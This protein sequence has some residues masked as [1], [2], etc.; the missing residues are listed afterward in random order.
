MGYGIRYGLV[1]GSGKGREVKIDGNLYLHRQAGHF[2]TMLG[3]M[4]SLCASGVG[5]VF[6]WAEAPKQADGYESW[7]G[8][9]TDRADALFVVY[10][11]PDNVFS[12]PATRT[13]V[14]ATLVGKGA[15]FVVGGSTYTKKQFAKTGTTAT[16]LMVVDVDATNK[17]LFVKVK[18]TKRQAN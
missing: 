14:N 2:V 5:Q 12:I 10:A 1:E 16:P 17:I 9:A 11:D 8:S 3:G 4:A 18:Q 7:K 15:G 13:T 6:G